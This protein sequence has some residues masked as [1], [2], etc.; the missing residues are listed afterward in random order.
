MFTALKNLLI[1]CQTAWFRKYL[2]L[3]L[4]V[5]DM[6]CPFSKVMTCRQKY[7]NDVNR[8]RI[9]EPEVEL[10]LMTSLL[11]RGTRSWRK[12]EFDCLKAAAY[13]DV[14]MRECTTESLQKLQIVI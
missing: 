3:C 6:R 9:Q 14:C 11:V 8:K 1:G 13:V 5:P 10:W 4:E 7:R 12:A 2:R